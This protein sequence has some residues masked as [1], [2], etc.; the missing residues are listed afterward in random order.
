[1]RADNRGEGGILAL[2][3]LVSPQAVGRRART[4]WW[5][6]VLGIFGAALLYGD[7]M[8]TPAISVL[9]AVEGSRS[10]RPSLEPY[11][12]PIA[13]VDPRRAVRGPAARDRRRRRG[14]RPGH[15]RVVHGARGAGRRG[16][17]AAPVVLAAFDPAQAPLLP[18]Q[19]LARLRRPRRGLPRGHRR[20]GAL[21]RHGTFRHGA[22]PPRLVHVVLPALLL[23]YFGQGALLLR[24]LRPR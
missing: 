9:G 11:I 22:D 8:I 1:M 4:R 16:D 24:D 23:N 20:R 6:V 19:R 15:A 21:R 10:R 5:L 2:M 18:P 12:V 7:G 17:P 14:V 3:A 13:V